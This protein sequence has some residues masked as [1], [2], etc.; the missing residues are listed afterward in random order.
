[1]SGGRPRPPVVMPAERGAAG[2]RGVAKSGVSREGEAGAGIATWRLGPFTP[3]GV[4]GLTHYRAYE[5]FS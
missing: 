2:C 3:K 5:D 4:G 1:M